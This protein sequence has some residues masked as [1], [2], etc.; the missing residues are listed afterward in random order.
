MMV[1]FGA[2]KQ[3]IFLI[4]HIVGSDCPG[5]SRAE[6]VDRLSVQIANFPLFLLAYWHVNH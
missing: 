3:I 6:M 5:F 2:L 4:W 1:I